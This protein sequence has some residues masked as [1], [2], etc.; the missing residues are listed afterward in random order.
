MS[1]VITPSRFAKHLKDSGFDSR[2]GNDEWHGFVVTFVDLTATRIRIGRYLPVLVHHPGQDVLSPEEIDGAIESASAYA[3]TA[4]SNFVVL[5]LCTPASEAQHHTAARACIA[6][7]DPADMT[8]IA[9]ARRG[10]AKEQAVVQALVR[11]LGRDTLSPYVMGQPAYGASFFGRSSI[12]D[13]LVGRTAPSLTIM[14]NRRIGKTS[15][16][17]ELRRRLRQTYD[18]VYTADLYASNCHSTFDV[19]HGLLEHVHPR[20]AYELAPHDV[21]R[22]PTILRQIAGNGRVFFFIDEADSL[23]ELDKRQGFECLNLLRAAA[24]QGLCR[25]FFAGFRRIMAAREQHDTP[26][27]NFTKAETLAGLSLHDTTDMVIKPLLNL[28]IDMRNTEVAAAI[29]RET[30]GYP[31][32]VQMFCEQLIALYEANG[33]PPSEAELLEQVFS[34]TL[35]QSK[36]FGTFLGSTN[37]L[38]QLT[39]YLLIREAGNQHIES[40]EFETQDIARVLRG[41]SVALGHAEAWKLVRHLLIGGVLAKVS[42]RERLKFSV[43]QLARY[44]VTIDLDQCIASSLRLVRSNDLVAQLE[45][46]PS[47]DPPADAARAVL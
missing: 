25:V 20:A 15:L 40:Y 26:L 47:A 44:C 46:E 39:A 31:E 23:V 7:L 14:G 6:I 21:Y 9:D 33:G 5:T 42:G 27:F 4:R 30:G 37:S 19:I 11:R 13:R 35:F 3:R 41:A 2:R 17:R 29:Y 8:A 22:F 28:G 1:T 32:L 18:E 16:L 45:S 34:S 12:L 36:V 38:E 10:P 24:E 43:P